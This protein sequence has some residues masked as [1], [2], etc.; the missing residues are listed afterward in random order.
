M[1]V[2]LTSES[3]RYKAVAVALGFV[4][5][6]RATNPDQIA[7]MLALFGLPFAEGGVDVPF[8]AAGACYAFVKAFCFLTGRPTDM[9]SMKAAVPAFAET[10]F[11]VSPQCSVLVE[12]ARARGQWLDNAQTPNPGDLVFFDFTG[13][14]IDH[15]EIVREAA[16]G[17]LKTV[18]FNTSSKSDPNGGAVAMR[19]RGMECVAGYLALRG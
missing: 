2:G 7:R 6:S 8:C 11:V 5:V 18:G 17:A 19:V 4:G 14:G 13:G 10:Y 1:S 12:H 15:V 16:A 9:A 3:L